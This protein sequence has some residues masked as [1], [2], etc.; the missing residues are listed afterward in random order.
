MRKYYCTAA[1]PVVHYSST[2]KTTFLREL[3]ATSPA[4]II[5][6]KEPYGPAWQ[7]DLLILMIDPMQEATSGLQNKQLYRFMLHYL[8][9]R[10]ETRS[11][12]G[13]V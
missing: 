6:G 9:R 7:I 1:V 10:H 2:E 12:K 11:S 13:P 3:S 8:T 4:T 5:Q